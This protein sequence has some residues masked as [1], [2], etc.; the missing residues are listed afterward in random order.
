MMD[1]LVTAIIGLIIM[2]GVYTISICWM[3]DGIE[4]AIKKGKKGKV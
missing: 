1:K 3:L 2:L 4:K